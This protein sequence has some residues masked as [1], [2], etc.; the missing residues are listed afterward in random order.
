LRFTVEN[1]YEKESLQFKLG[2]EKSEVLKQRRL[3]RSGRVYQYL[4]GG[5]GMLAMPS[6]ETG[7]SEA[8]SHAAVDRQL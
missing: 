5:S 7:W 4:C 1:R 2:M 8:L 3:T 6:E